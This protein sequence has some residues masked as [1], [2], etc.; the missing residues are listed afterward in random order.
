MT[1]G[2]YLFPRDDLKMES[3][4]LQLLWANIGSLVGNYIE[5]QIT[6]VIDYVVFSEDVHFIEDIK[7]KYQLQAKYIV[8]T[9][10]E[11]T[12]LNRDNSRLTDRMGARVI[13]LLHEFKAK[14]ISE[15]F[16]IDTTLKNSEEIVAEI[17]T[18]DRFFV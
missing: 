3:M 11:E 16:I 6:S 13:E 14:N 2:G 7:Q 17:I 1:V 12:L 18:N 15:Q 8:L 5:R 9:A 10:D 4:Y